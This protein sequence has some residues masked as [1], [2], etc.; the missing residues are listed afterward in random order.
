[1]PE[2]T[3]NVYTHHF[4]ITKLSPRGRQAADSFSRRN[5]QYGLRKERGK[6]IRAPLKVYAASTVDRREF[7]FHINQLNEFREHLKNNYIGEEMYDTVIHERPAPKKVVL[8]I[9]E[10]WNARDNQ[11]EAIQYANNVQRPHSKLIAIAT[12]MG[13]SF[14]TMRSSSDLCLRTMYIMRPS[15]IEKWIIDFHKTY[16]LDPDDILVVQGGESLLALFALAKEG[17]LDA[18]IILMSNKTLQLWLKLYKERGI[19]ILELGYPCLPHQMF[20]YLDV[21]RRVIDEVHMDFHLNFLIDL[22]THV[23]DS[24]SLSATLISDDATVQR[25]QEIA[26][27][28]KKRYDGAGYTPY[29][30][31]K[32]VIYGIQDMAKIRFQDYATKS[33]N[34]IIFEQSLMRS[35]KHLAKYLEL[36]RAVAD[37][38]YVNNHI[39]GNKLLIF[40]GSIEFCTVLTNFLKKAFPQHSVERYVEDDPYENLMKPDIRVST[41][42]SAGTAVDI[43]GLKAA[44]LTTAISS[45]ASNLQSLGRTRVMADGQNPYFVWFVCE[46]IPKHIEYH[47]KKRQVLEKRLLSY[48]SQHYGVC[49]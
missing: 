46:N 49:V 34:H 48:Q 16:D 29:I 25:M 44:I 33:Y 45:T 32:A 35:P 13:K 27:P 43:P 42:I 15:F 26:Y 11:L 9:R 24:L 2:L 7:R 10:G 6:F 12:G 21:G 28:V 17:K 19:E 14:I 38:V 39:E 40:A 5:M 30:R 22:Y 23:Y 36:I 31:G 41:V 47:E 37:D 4:S 3:L 8:K 1:M 20:E 18:K